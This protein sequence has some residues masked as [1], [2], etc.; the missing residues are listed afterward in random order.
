MEKETK[1]KATRKPRVKKVVADIVTSEEINDIKF[2][3]INLHDYDLMEINNVR[4]VRRDGVEMN[5]P[6]HN[7]PIA[8]PV[9]E[10]VLYIKHV[11]DKPY[12]KVYQPMLRLAD[13]TTNE[14]ALMY[15]WSDEKFPNPNY[16][17]EF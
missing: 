15:L 16:L 10:G 7:T 4:L 14:L 5:I 13:I 12:Y 2:R 1:P 9:Q 3:T 17:Y 6:M 11:A 8:N